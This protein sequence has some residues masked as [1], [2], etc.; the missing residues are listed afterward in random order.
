M[1]GSC[2]CVQAEALKH[3]CVSRLGRQS[4]SSPT[5]SGYTGARYGTPESALWH[6]VSPLVVQA[7][8]LPFVKTVSF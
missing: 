1:W 4:W 2:S 6:N 3:V 8:S 7:T 5:F